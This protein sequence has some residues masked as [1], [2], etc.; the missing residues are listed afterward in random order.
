MII[1]GDGEE[2]WGYNGRTL[3][4]ASYEE[5]DSLKVVIGDP[6]LLTKREV[7]EAIKEMKLEYVGMREFGGR[8]CHVIQSWQ[9]SVGGDFVTGSGDT[10]WIGAASYMP[11]KLVNDAITKSFIYDEINQVYNDEDFLPVFAEGNQPEEMKS[12]SGYTRRYMGLVDGSNGSIIFNW[13]W[14]NDT[15]GTLGTGLSIH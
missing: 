7:V 9:V 3:Y 14:S 1:G 10:W 15:G 6:F 4:R 11:V 13:G 12:K 8:L 2:C 5:M